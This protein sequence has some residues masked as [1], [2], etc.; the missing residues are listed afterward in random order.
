[1][2]QLIINWSEAWAP[3]ICLITYLLCNKKTA[4][5]SLL[6]VYVVAAIILNWLADFEWQCHYLMPRWLN[7]NNILYNIHSIVRTSVFA[8][9]FIRFA[10]DKK[11]KLFN[12]FLLLLYLLFA[13]INFIFIQSI[14]IF[15]SNLFSAEDIILL[16]MS[17]RCLW[18]IFS[19]ANNKDYLRRP[20][21]WIASGI[22]IYEAADFFIF[23]FYSSLLHSQT[24]FAAHI[25]NM[26]DGFYVLFC[27]FLSKA[28]YES[29]QQ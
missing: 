24:Y 20:L 7:S 29:A 15:S 2:V 4:G 11:E 17:L 3:V 1:M 16:I 18:H 28:I 19:D 26:H 23:V 14:M 5:A 8:T 9:I 25:W 6:L 10:A 13:L 27:L 22:S 12:F 21:F